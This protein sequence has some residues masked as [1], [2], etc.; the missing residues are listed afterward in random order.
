MSD[1]QVS[2]LII[3]LVVVGGVVAFN[4][5]Q[6]WRLRRRLE[7]AFGD[8]HEDVLLREDAPPDRTR[9]TDPHQAGADRV[10]PTLG[11]P[12]ASD[13]VEYVP[14]EEHLVLAATLPPV[15]GFDP[16]I[17]FIVSVDAA[18]PISA[19]GLAELHTRASVCGRRFRVAGY[20][21]AA[22]EWEEAARLSGGRYAH[23]KL[24]LQLVNRKGPVDLGALTTFCAAA[25]ECAERYGASARCPDIEETLAR[26]RELDAFCADVD[27]AIGV[28][29]I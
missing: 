3:G 25:Q 2:L 16:M 24:A 14:Q 27:V 4:W 29:L 5:L 11:V 15:P 18:E 28:N 19:A 22:R 12:A 10:E 6:Q 26:A 1:L 7:H 23:L 13:P 8:K 20:S 21:F 17:D 9:R